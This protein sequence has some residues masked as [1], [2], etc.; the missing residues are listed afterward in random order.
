MSPFV[1]RL[2]VPVCPRLSQLYRD[3]DTGL[4]YAV[5][6]YFSGGTG[7]FLTS[8]PLGIKAVSANDPRTFNAYTYVGDDPINYTDPDGLKMILNPPCGG[9]EATEAPS[10]LLEWRTVSSAWYLASSDLEN[11]DAPTT[12]P[13][14]TTLTDWPISNA[15][16]TIR[17]PQ[18]YA[19]HGRLERS[20]GGQQDCKSSR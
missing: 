18:S 12:A 4:D 19:R 6:R 1:P 7:R 9:G 11:W 8:D 2:S 13:V 20:H 10:L 5:N 17:M 14:R 16:Y 15:A 3:G